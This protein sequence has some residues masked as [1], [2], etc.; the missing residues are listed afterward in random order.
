MCTYLQLCDFNA[1]K[2]QYIMDP[3]HVSVS[4]TV[5]VEWRVKL[6]S[7]SQCAKLKWVNSMQ[8]HTDWMIDRDLLL[9][10]D[11]F[12]VGTDRLTLT[13]SEHDD[14]FVELTVDWPFPWPF[15]RTDWPTDLDLF[16]APWPIRCWLTQR[17]WP[18]QCTMTHSWC[19]PTAC[20][21]PPPSGGSPIERCRGQRF[22]LTRA[23]PTSRL[24]RREGTSSWSSSATS[25]SMRLVS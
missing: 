6:F 9:Y 3:V 18:F 14:P 21:P 2:P 11:P 7:V 1:S 15:H 17:P 19:T 5:W 10:T 4:C 25:R 12:M 8:E 16:C 22:R 20:P 23:C 13:F 24:E